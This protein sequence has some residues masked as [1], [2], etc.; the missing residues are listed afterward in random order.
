MITRNKQNYNYSVIPR[1]FYNVTSQ[2]FVVITRNKQNY[3]FV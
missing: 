1:S 3:N 2:N